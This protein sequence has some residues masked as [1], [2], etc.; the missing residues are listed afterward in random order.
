MLIVHVYWLGD[1]GKILEPWF[2]KEWHL[3]C[4]PNYLTTFGCSWNLCYGNDF[5]RLIFCWGPSQC[6][7]I[8]LNTFQTKWDKTDP[9]SLWYSDMFSGLREKASDVIFWLGHKLLYQMADVQ[10]IAP[11]ILKGV[12]FMIPNIENHY[13]NLNSRVNT[14]I[15]FSKICW[16]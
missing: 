14:I 15:L 8:T 9:N 16:I 2:N 10:N 4:T 11:T 5:K 1:L 13:F 6:W 3:N 7:Y 12:N